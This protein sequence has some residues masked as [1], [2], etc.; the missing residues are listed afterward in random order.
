MIDLTTTDEG[1]RVINAIARQEGDADFETIKTWL[2]AI[3]KNLNIDWVD[4]KDEELTRAQGAA[5]LMRDILAILN[6]PHK[7]IARI[8]S[9]EVRRQTA[10]RINE[11]L[12]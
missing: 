3:L 4:L 11:H 1:I 5:E 10:S 6:D 2:N 8:N 9:K 12:R 7:E